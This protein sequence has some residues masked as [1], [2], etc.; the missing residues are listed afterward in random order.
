MLRAQGNEPK[1][2]WDVPETSGSGGAPKCGTAKSVD[3]SHPGLPG[4]PRLGSP[5]AQARGALVRRERAHALGLKLRPGADLLR[6]TA[7]RPSVG[8][9][10]LGA[11]D[12]GKSSCGAVR[13]GD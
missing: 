8:P 4:A 5:R 6:L 9:D 7:Q 3:P 12:L 11:S 1:L 2:P 10:I 13:G